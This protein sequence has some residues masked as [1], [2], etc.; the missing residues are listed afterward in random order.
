MAQGSQKLASRAPRGG[1]GV[2]KRASKMRKGKLSRK[3]KKQKLAESHNKS[4]KLTAAIARNIERV[5]GKKLVQNGE[6]LSLLKK[7]RNAAR[8]GGNEVSAKASAP[9][10]DTRKQFRLTS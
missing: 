8:T 2:Q 5:T 7:V 1:R 6:D 9:K 4:K 10:F 3:P